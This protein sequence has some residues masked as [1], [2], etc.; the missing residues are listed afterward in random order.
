MKKSKSKSQKALDEVIKISN[1]KGNGI[2][3][4]SVDIDANGKLGRYSLTYVNINI[5]NVDNGRIL[6]YDNNHGYHHKHYMGKIEKVDFKSFEDI[7]NR[8]ENEW[9]EL[10]D[11]YQENE[12]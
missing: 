1:K 3:K 8:F 12:K 5:S 11:S 9:R 6:G 10:H 2:L 4:F 7:K